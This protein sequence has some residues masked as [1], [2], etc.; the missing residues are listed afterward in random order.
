MEIVHRDVSPQNILVDRSGVV[1]LADFGIAR[2]TE[3]LSQTATGVLKGKLPYVAPEQIRAEPYDHRVDLYALGVVLFELATGKPPFAAP[4]DAALIFQIVEGKPAMHLLDAVAAPLAD[5]IRRCMAQDP[6][7][8]M[9][10]ARALH[11]A[12]APLRDELQARRELGRLAQEATRVLA[13]VPIEATLAETIVDLPSR[14]R[15]GQR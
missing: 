15:G 7:A 6:A 2:T 8:R 9:P 3:R 14:K 12:L 1:K 13:E 10:D 4:S 5:A 11:A